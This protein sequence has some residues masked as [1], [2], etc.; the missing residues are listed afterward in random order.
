MFSVFIPFL[1]GFIFIFELLILLDF[2]FTFDWLIL[3]D[4][5][6]NYFFLYVNIYPWRNSIINLPVKIFKLFMFFNDCLKSFQILPLP[7]INDTSYGIARKKKLHVMNSSTIILFVY[8]DIFIFLRKNKLDT[9][10]LHKKLC[11]NIFFFSIVI[12]NFLKMFKILLIF[13]VE[14]FNLTIIIIINLFK[15]IVALHPLITTI[16]SQLLHKN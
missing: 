4:R 13:F 5:F 1:I 12:K 11:K 6:F 3:L 10:F 9:I 14:L 7:M 8:T 2:I 16:T 15:N